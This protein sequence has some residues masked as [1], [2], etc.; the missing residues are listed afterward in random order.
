[1]ATTTA[2]DAPSGAAARE[3]RPTT[4][5]ALALF[6]LPFNELIFRAQAAHRRHF[7][8]NEVQLSSK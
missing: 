5:D 2:T 6:G 1:M 3:P 4:E 7:D 8:P